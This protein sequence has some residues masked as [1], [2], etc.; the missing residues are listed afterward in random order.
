MQRCGNAPWKRTLDSD[1]C[2]YY[3]IGKG[4]GKWS[5][6]RVLWK[7][8]YGVISNRIKSPRRRERRTTCWALPQRFKGFY[9]EKSWTSYCLIA[10]MEGTLARCWPSMQ[11]CLQI[12]HACITICNGHQILV[13][14]PITSSL[15]PPTKQKLCLWT[16][17]RRPFGLRVPRWFPVEFHFQ[18]RKLPMHFHPFR[19]ATHGDHAKLPPYRQHCCHLCSCLGKA[20]FPSQQ[21]LEPKWLRESWK[22]TTNMNMN[23]FI[24]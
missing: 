7:S 8:A 22:S 10:R 18:L 15:S 1:H 6:C 5:K 12:Q 13:H 19:C 9:P 23:C 16:G 4:N 17:S 20:G 14:D 3:E 21:F 2:K 11:S 24:L